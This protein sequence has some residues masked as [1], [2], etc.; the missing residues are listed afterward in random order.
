M[1]IEI[2]WS[3]IIIDIE[4][5]LYRHIRSYFLAAAGVSWSILQNDIRLTRILVSNFFVSTTRRCINY[6]VLLRL[7]WCTAMTMKYLHTHANYLL[8]LRYI[9]N[10]LDFTITSI[11]YF[12]QCRWYIFRCKIRCFLDLPLFSFNQIWCFNFI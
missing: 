7:V 4:T 5:D 6:F 10:K 11:F 12:K 3:I 8:L 9:G 2:P 1:S